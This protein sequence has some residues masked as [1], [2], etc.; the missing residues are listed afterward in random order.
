M[1]S[2]FNFSNSFDVVVLITLGCAFKFFPRHLLEKLKSEISNEDKLLEKRREVYEEITSSLRVF[3]SSSRDTQQ[4][5]EDFLEAYSKAW[6]WAQEP[7]LKA[8][9]EYVKSVQRKSPM[10]DRKEL[11]NSVMVAMR[12]DIG[13][14]KTNQGFVFSDFEKNEGTEAS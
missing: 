4:K 2:L 5:Q 9:N 13:F 7:V 3:I 10:D 1:E 8:L 6:L 12:E 14:S 11:F